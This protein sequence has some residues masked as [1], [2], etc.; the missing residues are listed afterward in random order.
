MSIN[1]NLKIRHNAIT[2]CLLSIFAAYLVFRVFFGLDFTDEI[3]YYGEIYGLL[4]AGR[5]FSND[6]FIQQTGYALILPLLKIIFPV[7][8]NLDY[9][10]LK[11]R[12]LHTIL[13]FL[14]LLLVYLTYM[15]NKADKVGAALALGLI[16]L[17][18]VN[19]YVYAPS[20]NTMAFMFIVIVLAIWLNADLYGRIPLLAGLVV[21]LG[22]TYPTIGILTAVVLFAD[23]WLSTGFRTALQFSFTS[24]LFGIIL[25]LGLYL[26]SIF[27][28]KDL[29][30][31]INFSSAFGSG[32]AWL[33]NKSVALIILTI[34]L[35]TLTLTALFFATRVQLIL[36]RN[37]VPVF[38]FSAWLA[39]TGVAVALTAWWRFSVIFWYAS[40][41]L[42]LFAVG[43]DH[44]RRPT[45]VRIL[46]LTVCISV[47]MALTSGNGIGIFYRGFFIGIGFVYFELIQA[48]NQKSVPKQHLR[49]AYFV[50]FGLY[51]LI[52]LLIT[53]HPY[54]DAL[55]WNLFPSSS[56]VPAF[57]GVFI[58]SEKND[59]IIWAHNELTDIRE[60]Q[61]LLV[62]GPQ[63]WIYFVTETNMDTDMV[64]MHF[65]GQDRAFQILADNL[66]SRRPDYILITA[67]EMPASIRKI[68]DRVI[69][70]NK[71]DCHH[72]NFD[73]TFNEKLIEQTDY[74]ISNKVV[75]C[76][77]PS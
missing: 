14:T 17:A 2:I 36:K 63:P 50:G 34:A 53:A 51:A 44:Q 52:V 1:Y 66:S 37:Q 29:T 73:S 10:V 24:I 18:V 35:S 45:I 5:L 13:I 62:I 23:I 38:L 60:R 11:V 48:L 55:F 57:N 6:L 12:L 22:W 26:L 49:N 64:F 3:Q 77:L 71:Y 54:R 43:I 33:S 21:T 39:V 46:L 58:S 32:G 16:S 20:Y 8:S 7:T 56:N 31:S 47:I 72:K 27:S 70:N 41:F 42:I 74:E 59:S 75:L 4:S 28:I 65:R 9:F 15:R 68:L 40:L 25:F 67:N 19:F 69:T 76:K 30:N 61:D